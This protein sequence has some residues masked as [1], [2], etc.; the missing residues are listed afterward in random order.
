MNFT[1]GVL[2]PG[3]VESTRRVRTLQMAATTRYFNER[4]VPGLGGVWFGRQLF[5]A[6]LG[7]LVADRAATKGVRVSRIAA[8]NAIEALACWL[9]LQKGL[10]S[11]E[12][13]IRGSTLLSGQHDLSFRNVNRAGFYVS[14]PMR[15]ST[16]SALPALGFVDATGSRFNAFKCN[17][18]GE[19]FI[20]AVA[21]ELRPYNTDV[22][23]HLVRWIEGGEREV[24]VQTASLYGILSP[25]LP[26]PP[27]ACELLHAR[28]EQGAADEPAEDRQRR[29]DAL[30]WVRSRGRGAAPVIWK[31]RPAEITSEAHWADLHAGA[32]FFIARD[33]ALAVLDEV[34]L[35]IGTPER[36]FDPGA[37]LSPRVAAGLTTLRAAAQEYLGTRHSAAEAKAFCTE[38]T[39]V[40]D[41]AVLRRLAERDGR[42]LRLLGKQIGAGP[43]FRG[44]ER[45]SDPNEGAADAAPPADDPAWPEG[46][47]R[48]IHNLWWLG[49]DLDGRMDEW[50]APHVEEAGHA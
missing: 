50:L 22:V 16:V 9:A 37:I 46:I 30:R 41:V 17:A 11:G 49:L 12:K 2:G 13:R 3:Q 38:C 21:G 39:V 42:I 26:L 31:Q 7:V 45:D 14:Q 19:A 27:P 48:R 6:T 15:M 32:L 1:W 8:A 23:D 35:E 29:G 25:V 4:A 34:E 40:S 10:R 20:K 18:H 28:L 24:G 43:A 36:R 33:A 5:L 44:G 47:S